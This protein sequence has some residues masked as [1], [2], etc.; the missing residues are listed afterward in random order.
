[1]IWRGVFVLALVAIWFGVLGWAEGLRWNTPLA[2]RAQQALAG[3]DFHARF[4]SA[5]AAGEALSVSQLGDDGTGLQT[6]TLTR[7]R[8]ADFPILRYRITDFPRTLEL[9]VVFRRSDAPDDVQTISL[10]SP[11]RGEAVVDLSSL[12]EWRGEITELGFAEYATAQLVPPS[13]AR[14]FTPFSIERVELQPRAWTQLAAR[15]RT[16]WFAYRP[17]ALRSINTLGAPI[18]T[19]RAAPMQLVIGM[20]LLLSLAAVALILRPPPRRLGPATVAL[21][22]GAWLLLDLRWLDDLWAKHA[23]TE[24]VYAGK[25]WDER[26]ELQPDEA[27]FAAARQVMRLAHD[28]KTQRVL[29]AADSAYTLFR[30]M[31]FLRPFDVALFDEIAAAGSEPPHDALIVLFESDWK[32]DVATSVLKTPRASYP[33]TSLLEQGELRVYR[34]R[35]DRP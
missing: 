35:G 11:G 6:A 30:F 13:L 29:V 19:L 10:P 20:G 16:D 25:S 27:T 31:Y 14:T 26:A 33:V 32:F 4:G 7:L 3:Y 21:A 9:A 5:Q 24:S 15:L 8:A 17:W 22:F 2:P 12:A 23:L 28:A 18:E 34:M 1:M